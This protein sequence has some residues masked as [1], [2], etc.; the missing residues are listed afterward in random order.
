MAL[1]V[2][3][4]YIFDIGT[5]VDGDDIA[6]LDPEVVTND[7]VETSAAVIEIIVSED[8]QDGVLSLLAANQYGVAAEELERLH[9]VVG[10]S[11]DR[12][13]II[14]CI[15]YPVPRVSIKV[16][17]ALSGYRFEERTYINWLGFFFFF[18]MAV[19]VPSSSLRSAPEGSLEEI[20]LAL[21]AAKAG[22]ARRGTAA[23]GR[24]Q[25]LRT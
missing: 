20:G 15:G 21:V 13:V 3:K 24:I 6:V 8:D 14:H 5:R 23:R 1:C 12:V 16:P 18:R 25:S 22:S 19:A 17:W 4:T 10:K 7:T 2:I 11:D 9:R